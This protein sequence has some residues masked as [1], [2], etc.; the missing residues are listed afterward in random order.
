M[1]Y[2]QHA[3]A[4]RELDRHTIE[5]LGVPSLVLMERAALA[6]ADAV[7]ERGAGGCGRTRTRPYTIADAVGERGAG[8]C[9]V[10]VCG[11]GNNGG[12]GAACARILMG[13]GISSKI[14]LIGN[15]ERLSPDMQREVELA[16]RFGIPVCHGSSE[17]PGDAP[18]YID[19]L[20][21]IGLAREV[22]GDFAEAI[23][24]LNE[25]PGLVV[26]ADIPSGISADTGEVLGCAVR[27]DLTVTMQQGKPGLFLDPGRQ[28]AGEV[29]IADIGIFVEKAPFPDAIPE[30]LDSSTALVLEKTDLA[31][32]LPLRNPSG[33][34]GTFGKVT[35][36]AGSRNMAGAAIL[37][38]KAV[39]M[40]G[41]GMVRVV[42]PECNREILQIAVPEALLTTYDTENCRDVVKNA[43]SFGNVIAAGPGLGTDPDAVTLVKTLLKELRSPETSLVLD[44]DAL[45][46]LARESLLP[47]VPEGA[48]LTPHI[49]EMSRLSEI[50]PDEIV[51]D[52]LR[53]A[54]AFSERYRVHLLLKDA[55]TVIA[56][57]GLVFVNQTGT[58]GMATA[59][60]GDVLTG[61]LAGLLAQGADS[62]FAGTM[63]A[64]L[65]GLSGERAAKALGKRSMTAMDLCRFLPEA[66]QELLVDAY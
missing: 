29:R 43:L 12:D 26:A 6:I 36:F 17:I 1:K 19:A 9:V 64:F 37:A 16:E 48:F 55:R 42:T 35:L 33:N 49:V 63:A 53:V 10:A 41:A 39:L 62:R 30:V 21:G 23:R 66:F 24:R 25:A 13:R 5:D 32:L 28:Y 22:G 7:E 47:C 8:V 3:A 34:K 44:A 14:V 11:T 59:G 61:I 51:K 38:A 54:R 46:I 40:T 58:D 18:V 56:G 50:Q 65:H 20:F 57:D 52:R 15:P 2:L 27:A 60:S 45:N 31:H 4:M